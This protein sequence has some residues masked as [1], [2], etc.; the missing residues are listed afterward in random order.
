MGTLAPLK[1]TPRAQSPWIIQSTFRTTLHLLHSRARALCRGRESRGA[2]TR[3]PQTF[4]PRRNALCVFLSLSF[5]PSSPSS[6]STSLSPFSLSLRTRVMGEKQ[7]IVLGHESHA[8]RGCALW[9]K[10]GFASLHHYHL[11]QHCVLFL[12]RLTSH[13][14]L[15]ELDCSRITSTITEGAHRAATTT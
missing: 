11:Q 2:R 4:V 6:T 5:S 12:S 8:R 3:H 10:K 15:A 7:S 1:P 14:R 9:G 13:P